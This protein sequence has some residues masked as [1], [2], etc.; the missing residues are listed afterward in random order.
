MAAHIIT[1]ICYKIFALVRLAPVHFRFHR[2]HH[3]LSVE[4]LCRSTIDPTRLDHSASTLL[5]YSFQE[6]FSNRLFAVHT[7]YIAIN[8]IRNSFIVWKSNWKKS[9]AAATAAVAMV[10]ALTLNEIIIIMRQNEII[11]ELKNELNSSSSNHWILS[12]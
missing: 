12:E 10:M 7:N 8:A 5:F 6:N 2:T 11:Y 4:Y 9:S 1:K 3:F